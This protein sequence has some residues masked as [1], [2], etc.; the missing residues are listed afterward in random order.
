MYPD[1]GP[2]P[3]LGGRLT[4]SCKIKSSRVCY[5]VSHSVTQSQSHKASQRLGGEVRG[6]CGHC[7]P[8][9]PHPAGQ[10]DFLLRKAENQHRMFG[11]NCVF[12]DVRQLKGTDQRKE[13]KKQQLLRSSSSSLGMC[14]PGGRLGPEQRDS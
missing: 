12:L 7:P 1:S 11:A 10:G 9:D 6:R 14:S 13:E 4:T 5:D 8:G 2:L 3:L